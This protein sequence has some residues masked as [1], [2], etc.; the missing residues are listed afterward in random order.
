MLMILTVGFAFNYIPNS[1]ASV[2]FAIN[3]IAVLPITILLSFT[4]EELIL[5]TGET[6]GALINATFR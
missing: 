1:N 4:S 2:V 6:I 5:R 3:F